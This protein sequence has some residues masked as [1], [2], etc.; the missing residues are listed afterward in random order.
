MNQRIL[1]ELLN[2]FEK[3]GTNA[4]ADG[5][6]RVRR[7]REGR[8]LEQYELTPPHKRVREAIVAYTAGCLLDC[9]ARAILW[10][11]DVL[12]AR[13]RVKPQAKVNVSAAFEPRHTAVLSLDNM[14]SDS[15]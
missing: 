10:E 4:C 12:H 8:P 3:I 2:A 6:Y 15:V 9:E 1:V 5:A 7:D 13:M 14:A 11:H